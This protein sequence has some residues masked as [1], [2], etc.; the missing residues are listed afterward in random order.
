MRD[1]AGVAD[2]LARGAEGG[3]TEERGHGSTAGGRKRLGK[4][5][6]EKLRDEQDWVGL[7]YRL[8]PRS[9]GLAMFREKSKEPDSRYSYG[10][11]VRVR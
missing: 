9:V 11:G 5:E 2:G 3:L 10:A 4:A 7:A 1:G 6:E 8:G